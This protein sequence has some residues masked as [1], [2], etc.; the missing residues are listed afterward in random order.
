MLSIMVLLL[1]I[2]LSLQT[3]WAKNLIRE[4]VQTYIRDKTNT[5][6]EIGRLDFSFPKWIELDGLLM[7]DRAQDTLLLGK[8]VK[9]DVDML[10]LVQSKY[11][12][13]KVVIDQF[14][15]N[16]YNK[17]ADST[18]NYQFIPDAFKSKDTTRVLNL[19]VKD[20]DITH[21]R[22]KQKD[23]YSG[24]FM[25]VSLQKFHLNVDS[26]DLKDWRVG[27]HDLMADGLDISYVIT[28]IQKALSSAFF[29]AFQLSRNCLRFSRK[30]CD[31]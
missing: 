25:D 16:L 7:L 2:V 10:A 30:F 12:I 20:I 18:Y 21:A 29:I 9:I 31:A 5:T 6:F 1:I 27:I 24:N 14:Y 3:H 28:K 23:Y 26:I 8:H 22:L 15:V 4:K 13:N 11:V 17:D 19:K